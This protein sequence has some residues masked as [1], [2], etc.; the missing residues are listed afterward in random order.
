MS[1]CIT[2]DR[3]ERGGG[4]FIRVATPFA[5]VAVIDLAVLRRATSVGSRFRLAVLDFPVLVFAVFGFTF[6]G[7]REAVL[8]IVEGVREAVLLTDEGVFVTVLLTVE[9]VFV[10]VLLTVEGVF[11]TVFLAVLMKGLLLSE[12]V[13]LFVFILLKGPVGDRV[14][15]VPS[16]TGVAWGTVLPDISVIN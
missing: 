2:A 4:L 12:F 15:L 8:L 10:T 3:L 5:A 1:F 11:V 6:E 16:M 7:V 9:G 13:L 14:L